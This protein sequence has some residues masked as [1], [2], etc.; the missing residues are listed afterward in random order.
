MQFNI[1]FIGTRPYFTFLS[2]SCIIMRERV[3]EFGS[4][5]N[6]N[7]GTNLYLG[8]GR[9]CCKHFIEKYFFKQY[10]NIL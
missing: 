2:L 10:I 3:F 7:G 8:E 6:I 1:I 4:V 5:G 9:N